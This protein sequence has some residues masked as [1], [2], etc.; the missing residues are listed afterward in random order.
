MGS[1]GMSVWV[2]EFGGMLGGTPYLR[3][4]LLFFGN[5]FFFTGGTFFFGKVGKVGKEIADIFPK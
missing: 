4:V 2:G 3:E 1:S 5:Y